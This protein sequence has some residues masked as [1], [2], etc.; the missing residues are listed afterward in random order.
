MSDEI[1]Q[2]NGVSISNED[3]LI[4]IMESYVKV[5]NFETHQEYVKSWDEIIKFVK[6]DTA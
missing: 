3:N 2:F 4:L 1:I 5:M 6:G